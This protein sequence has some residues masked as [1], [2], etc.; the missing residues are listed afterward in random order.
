M[1]ASQA[2]VVEEVKL[3][4]VPPWMIYAQAVD[5]E[6]KLKLKDQVEVCSLGLHPRHFW[7]PPKLFEELSGFQVISGGSIARGSLTWTATAGPALG[8]GRWIC[9]LMAHSKAPS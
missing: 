3:V 1:I 2:P 8:L 7:G 4:F 9:L 5:S 6:W